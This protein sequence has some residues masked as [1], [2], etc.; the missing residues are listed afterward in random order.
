VSAPASAQVDPAAS[1]AREA[2]PVRLE[3]VLMRT[4]RFVRVTTQGSLEERLAGVKHRFAAG[5]AGMTV[6]LVLIA[7]SC[8]LLL[9]GLVILLSQYLTL[10]GSFLVVGAFSLVSGVLAFTLT[11]RH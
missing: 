7:S 8:L 3:D 4:L 9:A 10:A 11:T 2:E 6:A 5:A 1:P